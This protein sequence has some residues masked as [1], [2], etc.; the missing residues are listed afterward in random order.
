MS[1]DAVDQLTP[2]NAA[3]CLLMWLSRK[4]AAFEITSDGRLHVNLDAVQFPCGNCLP[5]DLATLILSLREELKQILLVD[6]TRH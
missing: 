4:G 3:A 1:N 5:E 6:E 2:A